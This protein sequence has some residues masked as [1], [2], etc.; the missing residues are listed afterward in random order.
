MDFRVA[1]GLMRHSDPRLTQNVYTD[2]MLLDMKGAVDS[3][4]NLVKKNC[5]EGRITG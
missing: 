1:V 3:L 5:I 2:P 4:S